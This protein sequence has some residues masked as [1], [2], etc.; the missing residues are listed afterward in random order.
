MKKRNLILLSVFF[1]LSTVSVADTGKPR[2]NL[3]VDT[4]GALDDFRALVMLMS[5]KDFHI[6]AITCSQ[7][8]LSST[9]C[10]DKVVSLKS[11][12]FHEGIPVGIG[13][14]IQAKLPPWNSFAE[15]IEWGFLKNNEPVTDANTVISNAVGGT[16]DKI[17]FLALGTL[18]TFA[19]W[20]KNNKD[21]ARNVD[22]IIWYNES[23]LKDGFNYSADSVAY[24]T[25]RNS[26][27]PLIMVSKGERD[28]L[29]SNE[30][31]KKIKSLRSLYASHLYKVLNKKE[32]AEKLEAG[33][34]QLWDD[35]LPLFLTNP[36][37]FTVI[38]KRGFANAILEKSIAASQVYQRISEI[39]IS[40]NE[41]MN[42]VFKSF[43]VMGSLYKDDYSKMLASVVNKYG[44]TEWKAIVMTNEVHGH[45]GI[46]SIIGAK[47]GIR[48]CEYFNVE[49]NYL[50][51][52]SFAGKKPPLSCFNDGIQISTGATIG[53][54]LI[55]IADTVLQ[56]PTVVFECN[57]QKVSFSLKVDVA[58]KMSKDIRNGIQKYGMTGEYWEYIE[59]LAKKYW[60]DYDR[61]EIFDIRRL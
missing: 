10:Y 41:S 5:G 52:V 15:S 17:T 54:G 57:K 50:V 43:P 2:Y 30:Y 13:N 59:E 45:T 53:Q 23:V 24:N 47:A 42:R 1:F 20:L 44:L 35:L 16:S 33:H 8:T 56:V 21:K 28:L 26:G 25:I 18:N 9:S 38:N 4:D 51:A 39:L 46:Y 29:C 40:K 22:K 3:V 6:G 31:L 32:V 12:F 58:A 61:H 27:I 60:I 19:D 55:S 37:L 11:L 36:E 49:V 48:A 7:G 34:S 14:T